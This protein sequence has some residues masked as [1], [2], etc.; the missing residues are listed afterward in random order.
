MRPSPTMPLP[1]RLISLLCLLVAV[2]APSRA[3]AEWIW[4]EGES[5][6]VNRM[7]RHPWWYDQVKKD[8]FSGAD[9]ISNFSEAK[10]GEAE[11]RFEAK[12]AGDHEFWVRANPLQAK[13]SYS[14]N[15][16]PDTA[17]DLQQDKRGEV[18][19]A[20]RKPG[21]WTVSCTFAHGL[22]L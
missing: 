14:L 13:L 17:I 2:L 9:F 12:T 20:A 11:Y 21:P 5:P 8:Q 1:G 10:A 18:N 3:F 4:I 22:G 7:N 6:A 16:G 19:V 15:G